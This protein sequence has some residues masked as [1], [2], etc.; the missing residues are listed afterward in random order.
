[1]Y[2]PYNIPYRKWDVHT[3]LINCMNEWVWIGDRNEKTIY[4]N[5]K[6]CEMIG[7]SLEEMIWRESYDFWDGDSKEKVRDVNIHE[8]VNGQSSSYEGILL[9]KSKKRIPVLLSGAPLPDGGTIGIMT[10]MSKIRQGEKTEKILSQALEHA[11]DG[12]ILLNAKWEILSWNHGAKKIFW[13]KKEEIENKSIAYLFPSIEVASM[14]NLWG[15]FVG[16][17]LMTHHKTDG[18][19]MV[20]VSLMRIFRDEDNSEVSSLCIVRDI[21]LLKRSELELSSRYEKIKDAYDWLWLVQR[22]SDYMTDLISLTSQEYDKKKVLGSIVHAITLL[23]NTDACELRI[24]NGEKGTLDHGSH[25]WFSGNIR[26]YKS[27][28]F[29]D[30]WWAMAYNTERT[31]HKIDITE[32][33]KIP[34]IKFFVRENFKSAITIWLRGKNTCAWSITILSQSDNIINIYENTFLQKYLKLVEIIV[35]ALR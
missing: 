32:D 18:E 9:S 7:Y 4:A 8:R 11:S 17:E 6:F 1:M 24:Y 27:I 23:S 19:R 28:P 15:E 35:N 31:Y 34:L 2:T 14:E 26:A 12:I 3:Q 25:F 29:E 5:P 33:K 30:S 10:D 21:T 13:Y 16:I 22:Q 20:Q